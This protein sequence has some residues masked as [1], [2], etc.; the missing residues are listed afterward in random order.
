MQLEKYCYADTH[1]F[2]GVCTVLQ[3]LQHQS[4]AIFYLVLNLRNLIFNISND[5]DTASDLMCIQI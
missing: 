1:K 5:E 2:K 4:N 3:K